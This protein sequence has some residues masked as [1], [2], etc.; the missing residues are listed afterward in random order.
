MDSKYNYTHCCIRPKQVFAMKILNSM[1]LKKG[2]TY[3]SD[4]DRE[5][6]SCAKICTLLQSKQCHIYRMMLQLCLKRIVC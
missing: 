3:T 4:F 5:N 6:S 2:K 1:K